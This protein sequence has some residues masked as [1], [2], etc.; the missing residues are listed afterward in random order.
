MSARNHRVSRR[1]FVK[2]AAAAVL[3]L[4]LSSQ[5]L[6]DDKKA[7]PSERLRPR[8]LGGRKRNLGP[9][10]PLPRPEGRSSPRRLRCRHPPPRAR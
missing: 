8:V 2:G 7:A 10:G 4:I 5:A 9:P 1:Q 6:G 3:P